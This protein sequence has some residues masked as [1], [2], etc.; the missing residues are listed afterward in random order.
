MAQ[1]EHAKAQGQPAVLSFDELMGSDIMR[2][3]AA[4]MFYHACGERPQSMSMMSRRIA[5]SCIPF[6]S[7]SAESAVIIISGHYVH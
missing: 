6:A 4:S 2:K 3:Q 7:Y 5:R 1:F